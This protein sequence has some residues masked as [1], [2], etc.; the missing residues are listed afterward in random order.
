MQAPLNN[1]DGATAI[2]RAKT[3]R[4]RIITALV[5]VVLL[6]G[7]VIATVLIVRAHQPNPLANM[8]TAQVQ[9]GTIVQTISETGTVNAQ[10]N[11]Q[12]NIA[13]Q[14]TGR[15]K[16]LYVDI[17]SHV[18]AGQVIAILDL[19]DIVAQYNQS[20]AALNAAQ[21]V[22][23]QQVSGVGFTQTTTS[24][25]INK[26]VAALAS[27]QATLKQD[28]DTLNAQ[29][30][31]AEAGVNQA[32]ATYQ[33]A[34]V[35]LNREK[36]LL[37][38][39]YVAKQDVDNA[40]AAANV[41]AAQLDSAKQNLRLVQVKTA[42]TIQTDEA[43][44]RSAEANL[45]AARAETANNVIK[46][47][48]VAAAAAAVRQAQANVDYAKAEYDKTIIRTPISGTITSLSAQAGDTIIAAG[49][50]SPT[51]VTVVDLKRLQV[52]AYVD[53]TDI[54][55]V[56]LGQAAQVTV[57]A[58]P[59][60]IFA[61]TVVK[62]SQGGALLQ[63]V[64]TYDTT[65]NLSNPQGLL[66]PGMTATVSIVVNKHANVLIAPIEAVKYIG[67][68]PVIYVVEGKNKIMPHQVTVGIA[69][70]TNTEILSGVS[71]GQTIILAGYPPSGTAPGAGAIRARGIGGGLS[72]GQH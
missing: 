39:G 28:T 27:A 54:G 35:F 52:D 65:I 60:K 37:A 22:Y 29:V 66:K 23:N 46:T 13:S 57:D 10:T 58:Y 32:N 36:E 71:E 38:K 5:A 16:N 50:S 72:S 43:A 20:V 2:R 61:G 64:V 21:Q 40:Q 47:Q 17:G 51:L 42:T 3:R 4:R 15:I 45:A 11:A 62:I 48:Q 6:A 59:N 69:D 18:T 19:P 25:D 53:E 12:V 24:S 41:A 67:T 49:L 44:V 63:N 33:N 7:G 14:I 70:N 26:A 31:V 56:R 1:P 55:G 34:V 9:R 30:L 8:V 68:T